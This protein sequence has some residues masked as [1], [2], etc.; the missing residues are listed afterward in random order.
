MYITKRKMLWNVQ[1]VFVLDFIDSKHIFIFSMFI[2]ILVG[3]TAR[4]YE[5]TSSIIQW[6]FESEKYAIFSFVSLM[7]L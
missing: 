7:Y 3:E 2:H 4:Q 6:N 1:L 5:N